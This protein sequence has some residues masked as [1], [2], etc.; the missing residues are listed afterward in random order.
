MSG[1]ESLNQKNFTIRGLKTPADKPPLGN[2]RGGKEERLVDSNRRV[3]SNE[4][5]SNI[6]MFSRS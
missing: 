3:E 2:G 4:P 1:H 6:Q 5:Q